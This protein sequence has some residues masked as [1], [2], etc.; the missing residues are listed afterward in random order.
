MCSVCAC[1]SS[2]P[3]ALKYVCRPRVCIRR[4][5][6]ARL[7]FNDPRNT[8]RRARTGPLS[9]FPDV[10]PVAR[11]TTDYIIIHIIIIL[12]Y[13]SASTTHTHTHQRPT[14]RRW[15]LVSQENRPA[16]DPLHRWV[17]ELGERPRTRTY[18]F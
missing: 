14:C 16:A 18:N 12:Y 9:L 13:T 15:R 2:C 8:Q 1:E 4:R 10:E 6:R 3:S 17:K 11:R 5:S 7:R